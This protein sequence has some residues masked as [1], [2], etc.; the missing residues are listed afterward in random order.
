M[1]KRM[2]LMF[3][4]ACLLTTSLWC[5]EDPMLGS[6]KF[7]PQKS[8]LIDEMKVTSLGGNKYAFDFGGGSPETIVADVT[9][10]PAN[11]G[12]T[13]AT[14]IVSPD[15]WRGQRKK[16]GKVQIIGIWKLSKDGNTCMMTSPTSLKTERPHI[17]FTSISIAGRDRGSRVIG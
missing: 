3:P 7:N 2:L 13:F 9:D 6:W 8:K 10:Q 16:D 11:F 15:E 12:T 5:A 14:T 1:F 4:L 17:L